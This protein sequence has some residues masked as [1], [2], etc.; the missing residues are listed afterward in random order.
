MGE[1]FISFVKHVDIKISHEY[2]FVSAK[3]FKFVFQGV[4]EFDGGIWGS[5][6]AANR[7]G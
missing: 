7:E 4:P 1:V 2:D 3:T 5:V 6:E